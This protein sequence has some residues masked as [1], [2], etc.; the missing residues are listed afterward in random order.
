MTADYYY[1][2][3]TNLY[4]SAGGLIPLSTG[5]TTVNENIGSLENKGF[6]LSLNTENIRTK[7]FSWHSTI[8]YS[9]N[10]NK[11]LSLGRLNS[12]QPTPPTGQIAQEIIKVGLPVGTFWGYSTNGLLTTADRYGS[13]PAPLLTPQQTNI[14]SSYAGDNI[15]II[16]TGASGTKIKF[17]GTYWKTTGTATLSTT[18]RAVIDLVFDGA[19]WVE[20]N[21][22]VQ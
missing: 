10:A 15:K 7:D 21:R 2:K 19:Y 6:E 22:T 9:H 8:I 1:K 4:I 12:F 5:Y 20:A 11:I 16:A 14:V 13:N 3:T 17:Y 18:G